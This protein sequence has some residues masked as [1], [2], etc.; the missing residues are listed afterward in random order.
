MPA[1][2]PVQIPTVKGGQ[3]ALGNAGV[4]AVGGLLA[5]LSR[6]LFGSS[7]FGHLLAAVVAGA[8]VK[9]PRGD[10]LAL[11]AGYQAISDPTLFAAPTPEAAPTV[12]VM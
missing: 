5:G 6:S 7:L 12:A 9:G 11:V 3:K 4:G 1:Q 8:F 10:T 2:V